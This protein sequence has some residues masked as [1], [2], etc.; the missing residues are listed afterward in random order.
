MDGHGQLSCR[1]GVSPCQGR[2]GWTAG[3]VPPDGLCLAAGTGDRLGLWPVGGPVYTRWCVY[4]AELPGVSSDSDSGIVLLGVVHLRGE[5]GVIATAAE[6]PSKQHGNRKQLA[7][8][9]VFVEQ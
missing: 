9:Q 5:T 4:R 1:V 8:G 3:R 6:I 2:P 7:A